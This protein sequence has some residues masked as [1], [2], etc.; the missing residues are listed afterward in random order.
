[1]S[2]IRPLG[3]YATPPLELLGPI[4]NQLSALEP[5]TRFF[6]AWTGTL[7]LAA[8][9]SILAGTSFVVY[10]LNQPQAERYL[11]TILAAMSEGGLR[12]APV[13]IQWSLSPPGIQPFGMAHPGVQ[14]LA[15]GQKTRVFRGFNRHRVWQP[16]FAP[17]HVPMDEFVPLSRTEVQ[18]EVK[19]LC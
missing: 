8:G 5:P 10:A 13:H 11:Q 7:P 12:I 16:H 17:P 14:P 15:D 1:L 4:L 19:N 2:L 18:M 6:K 9:P 3:H